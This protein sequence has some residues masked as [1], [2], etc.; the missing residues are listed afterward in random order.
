MTTPSTGTLVGGFVGTCLG[1]IFTGFLLAWRFNKFWSSRNSQSK[2]QEDIDGGRLRKGIQKEEYPPTRNSPS[3]SH[4][5][6]DGGRLGTKEIDGGRLGS[7]DHHDLD[8]GRL[9][10][11]DSVD[12][13][14][15]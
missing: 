12:K 10:P 13:E 7:K 11:S 14:D 5:K 15:L 6:I 9:G 3:K 8:G 1:G 4:N 2:N